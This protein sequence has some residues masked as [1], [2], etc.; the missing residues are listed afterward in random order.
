MSIFKAK[1]APTHGYQRLRFLQCCLSV[2]TSIYK[3]GKDVEIMIDRPNKKEHCQKKKKKK[4]FLGS[5]SGR[6]MYPVEGNA[7]YFGTEYRK[8]CN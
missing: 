4:E 2:P 8:M 1:E 6:K 3:P 7:S 5:L